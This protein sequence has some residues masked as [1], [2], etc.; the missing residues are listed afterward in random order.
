MIVVCGHL[1]VRPP[2]EAPGDV[3]GDAGLRDT[4]SKLGYKPP[5]GRDAAKFGGMLDLRSRTRLDTIIETN[6]RQARGYKDTGARPS[7]REG[8]KNDV[9]GIRRATAPARNKL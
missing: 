6:A 5:V 4:M 3:V 8:P 7:D 1:E 9:S 2:A